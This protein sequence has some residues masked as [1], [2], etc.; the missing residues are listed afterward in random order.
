MPYRSKTLLTAAIGIFVLA[1]VAIGA[2]FTQE[3]VVKNQTADPTV[4]GRPTSETAPEMTTKRD[5]P[6]Q[7]GVP[8]K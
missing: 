5:T 2:F 8:T 7:P 3:G 6:T 1:L 4:T